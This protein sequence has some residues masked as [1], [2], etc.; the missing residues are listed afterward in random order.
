MITDLSTTS[1]EV[2][3]T[4]S[5]REVLLF[6]AVL[7]V[8][9][10]SLAVSFGG[11]FFEVGYFL[12]VVISQTFAGAYIWAQLRKSDVN[13]PLPELLAMGFAIG[14]ASA[15]ISQLI[16]RDLLG[17]R[18]FLSPLIPIIGVAIWLITKR[19]PQLPVKVTHATTNTLLWLLF[20]APLALSFFVWELYLIFVI[21]LFLILLL[22]FKYQNKSFFLTIITLV[23]LSTIFAIFMRVTNTIS[24]AVGLIGNDELFDEAHSIGFSNW[25]INENLG[26]VGSS[27]SYYKFSHVWLGPILELT[28]A[29]PMVLS[30][31]AVPLFICTAIGLTFWMTSFRL[32]NSSVSAGMTAILIFLQSSLPEPFNLNIRLSQI[33]VIIYF[34][35]GIS[36]FVIS[37]QNHYCE[38]IATSLAISIVFATRAQYGI[39]LFLGLILYK[40]IMFIKGQSS[41]R[42][43]I[44]HLICC[45]AAI[46]CVIL[47]MFHQSQPQSDI[48]NPISRLKLIDLFFGGILIRVLIPL[49]AS[50]KQIG[51][52]IMLLLTTL[53]S[54]IVVFFVLPQSTLGDTPTLAIVLLSIF[55]IAHEFNFSLR[56]L[57]G[58][59]LIAVSLCAIALG[60]LLRIVY[61]LYKWKE[62]A[63]W[64]NETIRTRLIDGI[65][66]FSTDSNYITRYSL[67]V[68]VPI[69]L[70]SIVVLFAKN[71]LNK[72][73]ATVITLAVF[74]SFGVHIATT[75]RNVTEHF[76][77][78]NILTRELPDQS[79][80]KWLVE[81]N[82]VAALTWL[83]NHSHKDEIFAQNTSLLET[84]FGASLVIST[85][86][87]RRAYI[88]APKFGSNNDVLKSSRLR[89]SLDFAIAPTA[90]RLKNMDDQKVSWFVVDLANTHLRNWQPWATTRFINEDVAILELSQAAVPEPK[91]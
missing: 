88:E 62:R 13:L 86:T 45:T 54:S 35:V 80:A 79:P 36:L 10:Y 19:D 60:A 83:R 71:E 44:A 27:F 58:A 26:Q 66:K 70:I 3:E 85:F 12:L 73:R 89:T 11:P 37:W 76:R 2:V 67:I 1:S 17:I 50:R 34:I 74:L 33:L 90:E 16:I 51:M 41:I 72:L 30:T 61:D 24:I 20:P 25:G 87:H 14:S 57:K 64:S 65:I 81:P 8:E 29:S 82:R 56:T 68:F 4:N 53:F 31:T 52:P 32:F 43:Y 40:T 47:I 7:L 69:C 63:N 49:L 15:A 22:F 84:N 42:V 75:F 21:P 39:I 9:I 46:A 38:L 6:C 59:F 5:L 23:G 78:G 55:L 48:S 28:R 77:Y 18:L 91:N